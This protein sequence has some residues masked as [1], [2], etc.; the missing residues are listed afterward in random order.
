MVNHKWY[1]LSDFEP[2]ASHDYSY[3]NKSLQNSSS[4]QF[5]FLIPK[6]SEKNII[7]FLITQWTTK[8]TKKFETLEFKYQYEKQPH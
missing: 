4:N 2:I 6:I 3:N 7:N 8:G 1:H 5:L